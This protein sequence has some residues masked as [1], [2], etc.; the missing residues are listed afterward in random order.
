MPAGTGR[1]EAGTR[2]G[3]DYCRGPNKFQQFEIKRDER[4]VQENSGEGQRVRN[5]VLLRTLPNHLTKES[6]FQEEGERYNQHEYKMPKIREEPSG[7]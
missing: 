5:E 7:D 2:R 6:R 1:V 3:S 4:V